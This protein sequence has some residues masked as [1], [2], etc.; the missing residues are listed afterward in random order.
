[1]PRHLHL[2]GELQIAN[3]HQCRFQPEAAKND[4]EAVF[5]NRRKNA[6][7]LSPSRCTNSDDVL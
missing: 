6:L 2:I 7:G 3:L 5:N 1:M 4:K